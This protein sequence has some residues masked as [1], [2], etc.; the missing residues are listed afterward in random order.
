MIALTALAMTGNEDRIRSAGSDAYIARPMSVEAR[1]SSSVHAA[2]PRAA[3]ALQFPHGRPEA[4]S[5][6][7]RW[8]IAC[9]LLVNER[10]Q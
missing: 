6:L 4:R 5:D 10:R 1:G 3:G 2:L 7:S 8:L 9:M